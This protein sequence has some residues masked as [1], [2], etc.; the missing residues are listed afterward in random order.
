MIIKKIIKF[1]SKHVKFN[2]HLRSLDE[3][4]APN[5]FE[6]TKLGFS[7]LN[8]TPC[9]YHESIRKQPRK[10]EFTNSQQLAIDQGH[11]LK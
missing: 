10:R 11:E 3:A 4:N 6:L 9:E 1:L 2:P 8:Y 5:A 7:D